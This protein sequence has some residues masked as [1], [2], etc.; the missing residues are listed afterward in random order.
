MTKKKLPWLVVALRN[1]NDFETFFGSH[2]IHTSKSNCSHFNN[3]ELFCG[4][5]QIRL[6]TIFN[7]SQP[8]V[9]KMLFKKNWTLEIQKWEN[10]EVK[11]F[12]TVVHA[13]RAGIWKHGQHFNSLLPSA[14]TALEFE[15]EILQFVWFFSN[16]AFA[17]DFR[18][19]SWMNKML[20]LIISIIKLQLIFKNSRFQIGIYCG[21]LLFWKNF[22]FALWKE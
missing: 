19:I 13:K 14:S 2:L 22:E 8:L 7:T 11:R 4:Q 16:A 21:G 1:K 3:L 10:S 17:Q 20:Q 15:F 12:F 9:E 6:L 5:L 18:P